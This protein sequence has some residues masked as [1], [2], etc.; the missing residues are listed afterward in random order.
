MNYLLS[1]GL[2]ICFF[3]SHPFCLTS[4]Y[5]LLIFCISLTLS[6]CLSLYLAIYYPYL[7]FSIDLCIYILSLSLSVSNLLVLR[8]RVR[9]QYQLFGDA[10]GLARHHVHGHL[11]Q[12]VFKCRQVVPGA[13]ATL[14]RMLFV[15][16]Y[17]TMK[18]RG[19][20]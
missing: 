16:Q 20:G 2:T 19:I 17:R 15:I 3:F 18:E 8:R 7:S 5:V 9:R 12:R 6:I 10:T 13:R 14:S 1:S 4:L 11:S